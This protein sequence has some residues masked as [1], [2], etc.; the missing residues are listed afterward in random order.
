MKNICVFCGS[1][2]GKDEIYRAKAIKLGKLLAKN[3]LNLVYG[4]AN[5]G[6]MRILAD[7]MLEARAK[8]IGV[9]PEILV[10]KEIVH[11]SLT[12][13]HIVNSMQ[14]RKSL[15]ANLADAFIT[16]PGG[17]G[18]LDELSEILTWYQLEITNKPLAIFNIKGYFDF[19]LKFLDT[20]V[21]EGFLRTE[22]RDNIIVD[23]DEINLLNKIKTFEP[24]KVDSKWVEELK[25]A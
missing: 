20:A 14:E 11:K 2:M 9:M 22:H 8:V 17:F 23:D 5:I 1:N 25:K 15:M 19:F 6:I 10:N 12:E 16:M 18:T 21:D 7:T 3:N 13:I 4:G 24:I